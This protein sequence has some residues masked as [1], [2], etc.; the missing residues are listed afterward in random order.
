MRAVLLVFMLLAAVAVGGVAWISMTPEPPPVAEAPPE[1]PRAA[2]LVAAR[3]VRAGALLRA[4]DLGTV[5]MEIPSAPFGAVRDSREAREEMTGAMAR[6]TLPQG[7]PIRPH[8]VLRPGDRGFLAAV[9]APDMRA[10]AVSVDATTGAAG[11]IWPGDRVDLLLTQQ[12]NEEAV[13][14]YR[15]LFGETVL[16]D[17]R[18]IAVDQAI[19]QGAVG[20]APDAN[21]QQSRTVTLELTARQSEVV[22]V[23]TRL[24]RLSLLLRSAADPAPADAIA[25]SARDD[26]FGPQAMARPAMDFAPRA[27]RA[28]RASDQ[29]VPVPPGPAPSGPVWAGD[30]SPGLRQ[31][32]ADSAPP[33]TL[34]IYLGGSRREE[35]R[36]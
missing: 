14:V 30:V 12:M 20:E 34:Q 28:N 32:R 24:G 11:L 13:P 19:V 26:V 16:T 5:E 15:R 25:A 18:V 1:V 7:D 8:D 31:G 22:A 2:F 21:R 6:R 4:E 36:F 29:S 10:F 3:P 23:A 9:L 33:R 35:Y 17:V 27:S